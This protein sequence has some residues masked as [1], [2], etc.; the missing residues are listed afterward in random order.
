[1]GPICREV[2]SYTTSTRSGNSLW[3]I[4]SR[5][6]LQLKWC[7]PRRSTRQR[8]YQFIGNMTSH[9]VVISRHIIS[10][11]IG[12]LFSRWVLKLLHQLMWWPYSLNARISALLPWISRWM[13]YRNH[14]QGYVPPWVKAPSILCNVSSHQR[15]RPRRSLMGMSPRSLDSI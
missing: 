12:N 15:R 4:L 8:S 2:P 9:V 11:T 6:L 1:M 10:A 3:I 13:V 14:G 7:R 5:S